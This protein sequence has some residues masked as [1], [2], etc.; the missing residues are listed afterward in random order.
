MVI[1]TS[2]TAGLLAVLQLWQAQTLAL[3]VS[4]AYNEVLPIPNPQQNLI[5]CSLTS[6]SSFTE[7][8][9]PN[10]S[11]PSHSKIPTLPPTTHIHTYI[12]CS[13]FL[14]YFFLP[15]TL[16]SLIYLH[17]TNLSCLLAF[18]STRMDDFSGHLY[19]SLQYL[20]NSECLK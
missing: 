16:H 12:S 10:E 4:S 15:K 11:F 14:L 9:H 18:S 5:A 17:F 20:Q 3:T 7:R 6:F 13:P 8:H 2:T 19:C 1:Y